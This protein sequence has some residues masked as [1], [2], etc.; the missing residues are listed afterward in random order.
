MKK[1]ELKEALKLER[2]RNAILTVVT[3]DAMAELDAMTAEASEPEIEDIILNGPA[4]VLKWDDGSKTVSKVRDGD[5]WDPMFGIIACI[6]RKLTRNRGHGV[7]DNEPLIAEMAEDIRSLDDIDR[8]TDFCL[9]TLDALTILRDSADLWYDK[10]GPED[11][12]VAEELPADEYVKYVHTKDLSD[13][14]DELDRKHE[15]MRQTIRDLV[16]KGEL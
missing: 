7:D 11:E 5:K 1:R 6:F 16:D 3:L 15:E 2:S 10:L 4:T 12:P 8:M 14:M 13:Y 9:L